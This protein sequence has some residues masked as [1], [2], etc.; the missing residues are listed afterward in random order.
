MDKFRYTEWRNRKNMAHVVARELYDHRQDSDENEN[1]VNNVEHA[2]IVKE[3][4]EKMRAGWKAAR[5][6]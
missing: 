1:A 3:L 4:A 6:M 5:P 2:K